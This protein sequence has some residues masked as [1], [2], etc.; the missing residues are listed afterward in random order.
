MQQKII[1]FLSREHNGQKSEFVVCLELHS[2]RDA[3]KLDLEA[4]IQGLGHG[5]LTEGEGSVQLISLLQHA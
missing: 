5:T 3:S 4:F 1:A 2:D